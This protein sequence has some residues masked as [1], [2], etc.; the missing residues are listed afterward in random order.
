MAPISPVYAVVVSFL[1]I[2]TVPL[3]LFAGITT[4]FAFS[5]LMLRVA[6]VYFDIALSLVPEC[7]A[8]LKRGP[9]PAPVDD[10]VSASVADLIQQ[11]PTT[12]PSLP[13]L[14]R[15]PRR[16]P[17][18]SASVL[19]VE[20]SASLGSISLGLMPS[21]GLER[22]FEGV[23]GWRSGHDDD[24]W[25]TI[26]S[27]FEFPDRA[28]SRPPHPSPSVGPTTPGDGSVLMMKAR[29]SSPEGRPAILSSSPNS[30]R[31]RTPSVSRISISS[32]EGY[33]PLAM[34]PKASKKQ[35][36]HPL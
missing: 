3:A 27:R 32:S 25:T 17:G 16:R 18:S 34:S 13:A 4:F 8:R 24:T 15:G 29:T 5:M 35:A 31:P 28:L 10:L 30:F 19:S 6:V 26:N 1:L 11:A 22:D 2:I 9:T 36:V 12:P 7:L 23:G 14:N 20:S 21:I 33:C